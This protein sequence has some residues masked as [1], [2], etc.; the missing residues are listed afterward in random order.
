[1]TALNVCPPEECDSEFIY[2]CMLCTHLHSY[3]YTY[4]YVGIDE[5]FSSPPVDPLALCNF[6]VFWDGPLRIFSITVKPNQD[7][8]VNLA[9]GPAAH[10]GKL[11][12]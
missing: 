10:L 5:M 6:L 1:M 2:N 3:P 11:R 7:L 4:L 12:H 8:A 9:A